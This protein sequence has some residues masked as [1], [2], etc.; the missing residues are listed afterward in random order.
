MPRKAE[1]HRLRNGRWSEAGRI[2][3]I[4]AVTHQRQV[5]FDDLYTGRLLVRA[6][7]ACQTQCDTLCYV[8]MPDHF[9]WMI[10]L[11]DQAE[12]SATVQKAK[13]L[14]SRFVRRSDP[15]TGRIWQAGFHDH[16]LRSEEDIRDVAR[17]VVANP[18]R[19]GLVGSVRAY[20]LWDAVWL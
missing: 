16:A 4:T 19:A 7:M 15:N 11:H 14:T 17:Y 3:L 2:Y 8:V 1:G 13:S 5:L 6:L 12:L 9:H 18:L 10:Q 20:S